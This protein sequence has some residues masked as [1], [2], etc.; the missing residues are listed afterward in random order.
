MWELISST[1]AYGEILNKFGFI[2]LGLAQMSI[3]KFLKF[4]A[5]YL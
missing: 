5:I 2:T 1:S 4:F 3:K